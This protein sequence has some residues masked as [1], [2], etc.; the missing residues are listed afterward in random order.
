MCKVGGRGGMT[1]HQKGNNFM[2]TMKRKVLSL[3][4]ECLKG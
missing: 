2:K 3:D 4:M 1:N